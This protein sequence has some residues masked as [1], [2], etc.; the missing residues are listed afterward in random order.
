MVKLLPEE[1]KLSFEEV[2]L[3]Q[4]KGRKK[5]RIVP[6]PLGSRKFGKKAILI[7]KTFYANYLNR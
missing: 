7:S 2:L 6:T 4:K 3:R 5:Y 1:E